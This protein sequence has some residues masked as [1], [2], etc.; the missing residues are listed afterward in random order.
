MRQEFANQADVIKHASDS[1]HGN[2]MHLFFKQLIAGAQHFLDVQAAAD[3]THRLQ[4]LLQRPFP[5]MYWDLRLRVCG[6]SQGPV[7]ILD[8]KWELVEFAC[9]WPCDVEWSTACACH[10]D[11]SDHVFSLLDAAGE[12]PNYHA[13]VKAQTSI[14]QFAEM[15]GIP[16][17]AR[18]VLRIPSSHWRSAAMRWSR[19][20][21]G[22]FRTARPAWTQFYSN[23]TRIVTTPPRPWKKQLMNVQRYVSDFRFNDGGFDINDCIPRHAH[24]G[25]DM[26]RLPLSWSFLPY[27][28]LAKEHAQVN[29]SGRKWLESIGAGAGNLQCIPLLPHAQYDIG[30]RPGVSNWMLH[31]GFANAIRHSD[32]DIV[33]TCEDKDSAVLW[34]QIG[35]M[36]MHRWLQML[37]SAPGRWRLELMDPGHVLEHYRAAFD[38]CLPKF[39]LSGDTAL[40]LKHV[41]NHY[42]K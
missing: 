21:I 41:P 1:R 3:R 39:P 32:S 15:A 25:L 27:Q 26:L 36:M 16:I 6:A 28:S 19:R 29:V 12:L 11:G 9:I 17:C 20:A 37:S 4:L 42:I 24:A 2:A 18:P 38:G 33:I 40:S 7:T 13:R 23:R 30:K 34:L 14:K 22:I 8:R 10:P 5:V 35:P 31:D